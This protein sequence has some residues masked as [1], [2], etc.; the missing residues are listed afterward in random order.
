MSIANVVK[1]VLQV[2]DMALALLPESHRTKAIDRVQ[3]A[4]ESRKRVMAYARQK[5]E[6]R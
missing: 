1:V 3:K 5:F 2:L 6:K 4:M